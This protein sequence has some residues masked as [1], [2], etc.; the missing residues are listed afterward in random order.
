MYANGIQLHKAV[1]ILS[2]Y[3]SAPVF[4]W[5]ANF[6][7]FHLSI[8]IYQCNQRGSLLRFCQILTNFKLQYDPC[9]ANSKLIKNYF[10]LLNFSVY[11]HIHKTRALDSMLG[12][13]NPAQIFTPCFS[14][15]ALIPSLYLPFK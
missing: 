3:A 10:S 14:K 13:W 2:M 11:P 5:P 12:Q 1:E 15:T 4:L 7:D 6:S 9:K 8:S